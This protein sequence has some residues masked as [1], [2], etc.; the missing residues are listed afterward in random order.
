MVK[1]KLVSRAANYTFPRISFPH[2]KFDLRWY[3]SAALNVLLWRSVKLL[4]SFNGYQTVLKY[5]AVLIAFLPRIDEM[6]KKANGSSLEL[7]KSEEP[8]QA[9]TST[10]EPRPYKER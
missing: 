6:K 10:K 2:G 7:I 3:Y 1:V 9:T 5:F 8:R 4:I